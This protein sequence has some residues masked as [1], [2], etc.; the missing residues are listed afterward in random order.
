LPGGDF[1]SRAARVAVHAAGQNVDTVHTYS[2]VI[3]VGP[4]GAN[5]IDGTLARLLVEIP[6]D[7]LVECCGAIAE[8]TGIGLAERPGPMLTRGF[9]TADEMMLREAFVGGS[10]GEAWTEEQ[11]ARA[12]SWTRAFGA[13]LRH[14]GSQRALGVT[15]AT[16]VRA[17]LTEP[18]QTAL[19]WPRVG[20][21]PVHPEFARA[22]ACALALAMVSPRGALTVARAAGPNTEEMLDSLGRAGAWPAD[23]GVLAPRL[24]AALARETWA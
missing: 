17:V 2:R 12:L 20:E 14:P 3:S 15:G 5:P 1:W 11:V 23:F 19:A 18:L 7:V 9:G 21:P 6:R 16:V 10:F 24:R 4:F 8:H 22:S 13:L